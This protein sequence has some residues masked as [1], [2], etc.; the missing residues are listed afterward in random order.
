M[1]QYRQTEAHQGN[2]APGRNVRECVHFDRVQPRPP[3]FG[4]LGGLVRSHARTERDELHSA[5]ARSV[6]ESKGRGA[7]FVPR[8]VCVA[9]H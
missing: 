5:L 7:Q 6:A 3:M 8:S 1:G 9:E 2:Q 4:G